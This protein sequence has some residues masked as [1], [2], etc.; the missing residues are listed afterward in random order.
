MMKDPEFVIEEVTDPTEIARHRTQH[1]R[2]KRN[3][4]W[5]QAHWGDLLPQARGK[6][7]AVAR[8]EAFIADTPEDAWAWATKNHP[9]D[10]GALVRYMRVGQGPRIYA[11]TESWAR[12]VAFPS[13]VFAS[14]NRQAESPAIVK[15][16]VTSATTSVL[17]AAA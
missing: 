5:L 8:E 14:M 13:G 4:D 17:T 15:F 1:E 6:F 3:G 11:T 2:A 16:F 9:D 7:V 10:N 12:P